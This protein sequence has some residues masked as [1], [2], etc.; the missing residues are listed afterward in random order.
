MTASGPFAMGP[1]L[2][3][4]SAQRSTPRSNFA[5]IVPQGAAKGSALGANLSN[6]AAPTLKK[7]KQRE[8]PSVDPVQPPKNESDNDVYS[9]PDEGV[10][11]IDMENVRQLD[12][13]AP[14]TLQR[15]QRDRRKRKQVKTEVDELPSVSQG[16]SSSPLLVGINL[17]GYIGH[18]AENADHSNAL[19]LSESEEEEPE[20]LLQDFAMQARLA[21]VCILSGIMNVNRQRFQEGTRQERLYFFQFP[22][23]FPTFASTSMDVDTPDPGPSTLKR[24][25]S[26]A[27]DVRPSTPASGSTTLEAPKETP[28]VD[29]VI[30]H[31]EVYRSG[32]VKMR[33]GNGIVLNVR[34]FFSTIFMIYN[35]SIPGVRGNT[36]IVPA[37]SGSLEHGK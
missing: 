36:T 3:G 35:K 9:E 6:S 8:N 7:E 33:L 28:K 5:P 10:E 13:M 15:D 21:E 34:P 18:S 17:C 12:W 30:G 23:P 4:T 22:E 14:E 1:T 26:F 37:A 31:V 2:A 27:V 20:D 19:D 16:N 24:K 29:G 11:I 32:A 25:V